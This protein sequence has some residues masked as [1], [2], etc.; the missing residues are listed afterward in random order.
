[1]L[2]LTLRMRWC[3]GN[4]TAEPGD[5][6]QRKNPVLMLDGHVRSGLD[7]LSVICF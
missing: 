5:R 6:S 3:I 4:L 2:L 1:M 7:A